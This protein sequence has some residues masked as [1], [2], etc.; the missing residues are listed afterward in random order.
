MTTRRPAVLAADG[1]L[2]VLALLDVWLN[3]DYT[4]DLELVCAAVAAVALVLRRRFPYVVF[5]VTMPALFLGPTVIAALIALYTVAVHTRDR[6]V[7]V[8]CA[9]LVAV[10]CAF[11]WPPSGV[12]DSTRSTVLLD[13]LYATMAA[14]AP[15]LLGILTRTHNEL[16]E[17]LVEIE[18]AREQERV[19]IEQKTLARERTQLA[20]EMHDVVSHQVSLIAVSAGA[21]QVGAP[22]SETKEAAST[23]RSLSV[24]TLDELR[25]MVTLLRASGSRPTE[26]TPQPTLAELERLIATSGVGAEVRGGLPGDISAPLQRAIYR[27]VQESLTNVRKHAPGAAV[28]IHIGQTGDGLAV[29]IVNGPPTRT[30]VPLPSAQH[31]LVGLRERAELLG[32]TLTAGPT[33]E[34]GF[35]V[36]LRVPADAG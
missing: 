31:G 25:H 20:R 9:V 8:G 34:G 29:G 33:P 18:Q 12:G 28:T 27:T 5:A 17:R 30:P 23:I 19:L 15:A 3:L 13:V 14:A 1:A 35:A 4:D 10:G 16:R 21:L 11:P 26:L 24:N 2:V 6:R 7:A 22:D 32:G 36:R